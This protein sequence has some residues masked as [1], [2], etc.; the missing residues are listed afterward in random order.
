MHET[1]IGK[2]VGDPVNGFKTRMNNHISESRKGISSCNSPLIY[3]IA[4]NKIINN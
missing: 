2:T 3:L 4:A 1:Y